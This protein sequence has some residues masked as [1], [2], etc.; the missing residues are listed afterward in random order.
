MVF[1]LNLNKMQYENFF[2]N[3]KNIKNE[4]DIS[5]FAKSLPP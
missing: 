2:K 5:D 1:R 4:N 3:G